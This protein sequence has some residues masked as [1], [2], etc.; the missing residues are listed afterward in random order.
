VR[1]NQMVT[2]RHPITGANVTIPLRL[3]EDTPR[4]EHGSD[5]I[6]Y[7]YGTYTVRAVFLPDGSVDTIYRNPLRAVRFD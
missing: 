2:F 1:P 6:I 3:P 4:I 5:R 7:N